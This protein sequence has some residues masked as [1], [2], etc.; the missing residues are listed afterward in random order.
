MLRAP[1]S[2]EHMREFHK[3]SWRTLWE[4]KLSDKQTHADNEFYIWQERRPKTK[5]AGW[6]TDCEAPHQSYQVADECSGTVFSEQPLAICCT[7]QR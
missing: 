4:T 2:L 1:P 3:C 7:T 6:P 5:A